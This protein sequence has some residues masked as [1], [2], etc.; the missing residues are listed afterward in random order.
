M[1][2]D[3]AIDTEK[4]SLLEDFNVDVEVEN[5]AFETFSLCFWVYLLDS[6]TYPSTIIRQVHSDMSVS[7]PFLV[8]DENKKMMLLPLTLLHNEAPDPVNISSWTE[9][10]NVSTTAEFPLQKW[11]HVGCEVSRNYMRLYICGEIVGEQVLT[12]LMTNS[13]NS[14]CARKISLFSVGGDGYSV[15]GFIHCAEVLPSNVPANYHYTKDPPLWLSVDKPSTSGIG[16]D[17][18]GVWIIVSGTFCSLDVVLTNAIGQ[19]VHKDVK[20]VASLLYA[21]SGMPVEKMSDSEA[22]LLVSYEGVEFSAE[23]KPC[24]LLNGCASFKLKLSQLSSKSDKRLFCVKFEIPE[25]KAYY[26][27]LE[28]VTNQIRCISRNHD[29]LTPKRSNRIDYPL[30]GGEPELASRS[31]GTSDILHSSSSMKRIRLG[32]EKVSES[33]T[34]NGNGTSMEWR[35]QNHEEEDEEDNSSTDS[36]NTEIRDSTAFR[37]YTISDSIIFKYCLGNLTE[38]ALLLKEI[39]NNSSDEEVSEFVDQVSL[40]S[41]CFHHSYQIKMARQLIAEGT[42]AWNLISRNYQHV[43]WDNVVIEIEEHF[44]RIAKC[45]SRSLTHQDFDL[46]R[47]ICGCY[48]YITQENFEKMWCWLFPVASAISRGLINGMWRS[49]SPKWIEGFVTKEEA[50]RSL[51]NQVAGTF[52]L[53]F[54]T[55]RSWPHP[56]A[57]SLVVTYVGHDLVIHHRLLTIDHICDSSERYTDAKP[58]QDMLLAE[59]ELSRLGRI[60]RGI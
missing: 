9:V 12:S 10:P 32:E 29:S 24:N 26:P 55:S 41:G 31:N 19:P 28:T 5:K 7:A 20:V 40:Y 8:L 39:T 23:D 2:G 58:L 43:H 6:T 47:R 1:A 11:V 14:D 60:I 15:Q 36:E 38:R 52:I 57:G 4:Y 21:D 3:C 44:M 51:Q 49:A 16:L 45:S 35:P 42:N 22:P 54:P 50:E 33:E 27:F 59:P 17:K 37:R 30:D 46:L 25:V 53:R 18:D 13:T 56:D 34:E 48:E